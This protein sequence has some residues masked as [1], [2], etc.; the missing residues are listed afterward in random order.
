MISRIDLVPADEFRSVVLSSRS[1]R[2]VLLKLGVSYRGHTYKTLRARLDRE[3]LSNFYRRR[4]V[5][6][7]TDEQVFC[8]NSPVT[9]KLKARYLRYTSKRDICVLCGQGPHHNGMDLTL[10]LDHIN[11][12]HD[13]NR[14]ENLRILCPNCHSQTVTYGS[15]NSTVAGYRRSIVDDDNHL[16][17]FS[18]MQEP[19]SL[20]EL[21]QLITSNTVDSVCAKLGITKRKEL[22]SFCRSLKLTV[23]VRKQSKKFSVTRTD[24]EQLLVDMP[25]TSIAK[26]FGVSNTAIKKRCISLGI[27]LQPM[28]GVWSKRRS[29]Q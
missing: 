20:G 8:E 5:R 11:G 27:E 1:L 28:R 26:M 29:K 18:G 25:M 10:Q 22:V 6:R 17:Q 19:C 2:E 9:C 7:Y 14:V 4:T 16:V 12:I 23:L 21:K 24:L 3:G 13:D 15:R